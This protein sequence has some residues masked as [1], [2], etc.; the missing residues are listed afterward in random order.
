MID[1]RHIPKRHWIKVRLHLSND[2][3][4]LKKIVVHAATR[5]L[6]RP[7]RQKY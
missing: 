7:S 3:I 6:A 4:S 5:F 2:I 1:V